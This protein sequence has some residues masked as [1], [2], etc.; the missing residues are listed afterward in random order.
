MATLD[1]LILKVNDLAESLRFYTEVMGFIDAGRD[2]PFTVI[3]AGPDCQLQLAPWGTPGF[4]HYAFAVSPAE[5]EAIFGRIKAAGLGYGPTF[6]S[7]G[8]NTGP[9]SESGARGFAPTLY[10][11]DPNRHLIEIRTYGA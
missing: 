6:D 10:F 1:H 2:G 3:K 9:G 7:V 8:T 4:E 11:N 5:F